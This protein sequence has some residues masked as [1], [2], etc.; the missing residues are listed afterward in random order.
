MSAEQSHQE[1]RITLSLF[2]G[3]GKVI[4]EKMERTQG[5]GAGDPGSYLSSATN[6][7]GDL[8][9]VPSTVWTLF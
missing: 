8:G 5:W 1:K 4:K 7:V 3:Y 6:S 2:Q 9:H